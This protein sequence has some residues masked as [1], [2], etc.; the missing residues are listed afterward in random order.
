MP[1][2]IAEKID[3]FDQLAQ[4]LGFDQKLTLIELGPGEG[5][6]VADLIEVLLQIKPLI[7]SFLKMNFTTGSAI[8]SKFS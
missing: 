6:L 2:N 7:L 1:E 4:E 3:S 8:T 5:T